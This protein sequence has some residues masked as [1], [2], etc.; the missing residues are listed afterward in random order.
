MSRFNLIDEAWIPVRTL[1][2]RREELGVRD[3]LLR[4]KFLA[5]IEDPSPLVTASLHRFL[6]AVLYRALKGPADI[7]EARA[8]FRSGLPAEGITAYLARWHDRFWLFDDM[9]PFGQ[10][11]NFEPKTWRAWTVLAAEHN[12]D[13]AKVLFDHIDVERPYA[14]SPAA[15][16]RW[17]LATQT[18]SVS[19]GKSELSH[20]GTAPSATAAMV[21][22]LGQNLED[23]LL[24][25]LVPQNSAILSGDLP[26]WER[27]AESVASLKAGAERSISGYADRYTWRTRAIRLCDDG[28]GNVEKLAFASGVENASKDAIDPML[29][30]RLDDKQGKL[31]PRQF[32]ERGLWREFHSLLPDDTQLAPG[33]IENATR[34]ARGQRERFPASVMVLGQANDKAKIEYWRMEHYALP[35]ALAGD[36]SVRSEIRQLLSDAE[37][38][39]KALWQAT[40]AFARDVLSRGEREPDAKDVGR[41]VEQ[42]PASTLYWSRL[43]A[44][45]HDLLRTYVLERDPD[46]IRLSWLRTVRAALHDAWSQHS[47]LV[48]TGDAWAIRALVKA[49]GVITR[50]LKVLNESIQ[51]YEMHRK[52]QEETA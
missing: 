36:R 43:E 26:L 10:I 17:M 7:D 9:L 30:Y 12:A 6:L 52:V 24:F 51:K 33:V 40:R 35:Q 44:A 32:G 29:A 45:F 41:F 49:E 5:V 13:N 20:T 19:A 37:D 3:I 18:F 22:S 11:H 23:T 34:I 50:K 42:L 25:A 38:A 39:Q 31:L 48:S 4:A 2:G 27:S 16:A 1:D 28:N 15:A 47:A 8:L 21:L 46:D 14:I